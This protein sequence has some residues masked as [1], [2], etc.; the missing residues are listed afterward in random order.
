MA[1]PD[2]NEFLS[3]MKRLETVRS[4][5]GLVGPA[6]MEAFAKREAKK[7]EKDERPFS[8]RFASTMLDTYSEIEWRKG[9]YVP[10]ISQLSIEEVTELMEL[11]WFKRASNPEESA[12]A[13][14]SLFNYMALHDPA[15]IK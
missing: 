1:L 10:F 4:S 2:E 13:V 5:T 15:V 11:P 8:E 9:G 3:R 12:A 7:E 6:L 14:Q